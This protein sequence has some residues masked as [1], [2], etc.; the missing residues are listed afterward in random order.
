MSRKGNK[1]RKKHKKPNPI[2]EKKYNEGYAHGKIAGINQATQFFAEK[3]KNLSKRKGIGEKTMEKIKE[4]LGKEY[5]IHERGN[6][7]DD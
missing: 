2:L 4:E 6:K 1:R 3:F 7:K 5:F